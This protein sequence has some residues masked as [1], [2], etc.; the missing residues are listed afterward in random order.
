MLSLTPDLLYTASYMDNQVDGFDGKALAYQLGIQP[1][2]SVLLHFIFPIEIV[3]KELTTLIYAGGG[4]TLPIYPVNYY[5]FN[6]AMGT[7]FDFK[8]L[9]LGIK[10][11][12]RGVNTTADASIF[13][14]VIETR[15]SLMLGRRWF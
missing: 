15:I 2:A 11:N 5:N 4:W 6:I 8:G 10:A 9:L 3:P 1:S 12:V 13:L 7:Y 14:N